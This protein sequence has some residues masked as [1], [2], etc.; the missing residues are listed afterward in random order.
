MVVLVAPIVPNVVFSFQGLAETEFVVSPPAEK[1]PDRGRRPGE[2]N[3]VQRGHPQEST[4]D[5]PGPAQADRGE[6]GHRRRKGM[7]I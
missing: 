6:G 7:Y 4:P 1:A 5:A 3:R 2:L